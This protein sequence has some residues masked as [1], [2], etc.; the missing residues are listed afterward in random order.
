M[1]HARCAGILLVAGLLGCSRGG[2]TPQPPP[3]PPALPGLV[4]GPTP[5]AVN[6]TPGQVGTLYADSEV[7][8]WVAV[9][10]VNSQNLIGV[11]Q[12]DRWS[13]GS[14]RGLMAGISFDGGATWTTQ[15][16]AFSRCAGGNPANGGDFDRAT[17]PWISFGA[18]GTAY[19]MSLSTSGALNA[20]LVARSTDGG[21]TWSRATALITDGASAFND[22]N[23]LT[24]D[25]VDAR[26]VYAVWDRLPE[27]GGGPALFARTTN[28]GATWEPAK[29]IFDPGLRGQTIGN[30]IVVLPSGALVNV[31][32]LLE[33]GP[34]NTTLAK[35]AVI[36]STDRGVTWSGPTLVADMLSLGAQDPETGTPVRD[37]S[38]IPQAAVAPDGTVAVVWQDARFSAGLRDGI[39]L[40]RSTDG[41]LTWSA[42]VRVNPSSQHTAFT[43]TLAY[44][45]DGT[46]G[47]SY[48]DFR[49]NTADPGTLP[50]G[51]YL[52]RS[53]QGSS[54][55]ETVIAEPFDLATAPNARGLFLGD[56][57][58]LVSHGNGFLA[59]FGRT[60]GSLTNR[61]DICAVRVGAQA[62]GV[63]EATHQAHASAPD[64][65]P[66]PAFRRHVSDRILQRLTRPP[67]WAR[68]KAPEL[69][70]AKSSQQHRVVR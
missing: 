2:G 50:T 52:A 24:A 32:T 58:G 21:R 62:A 51:Y 3:P 33:E 38:I 56:Y 37:G 14:A 22:K 12:Q 53:N 69:A 61:T 47:V 35:V 36:R 64:W 20:M 11:W 40:S 4:S 7:E 70:R 27:A 63:S 29:A 28:G 45:P 60:T 23:T 1:M 31:F 17:D 42:P 8:P 54:W 13:N 55:T 18:D 46:L 6:C 26:Y 44:R 48:Y 19:A 15:P 39:A 59:F 41:G 57:Q 67:C 68:S 34:N 49:A 9:N 5:F 66:G 43:P 25:P 65:V 16:L 10:P 30:V